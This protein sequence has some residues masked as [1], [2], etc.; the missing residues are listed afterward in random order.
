M[1]F[2]TL[3]DDHQLFVDS[4]RTGLNLIPDISVVDTVYDGRALLDSLAADTPDVV[5]MDLEMPN[6]DG[7]GVLASDR[8]LPPIVVV[9]MHATESERRAAIEAGASA[10]L[11]K[12]TPLQDLAA[13]IRALALGISLHDPVTLREILDAHQEPVLQPGPA[14]LTTREKELLRLLASGITSTGDLAEQLYISEKT[15]KNHLASIYVKLSV[16]DRAQ[17]AV[18]AIRIGLSDPRTK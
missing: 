16:A 1:I 18:E 12:S 6:L 9:T 14:S 5:V 3:A 4:L 8:P 7:H 15:V 2:V 17:A 13:A 11:P 10:F